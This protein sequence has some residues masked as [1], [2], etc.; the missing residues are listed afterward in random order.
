MEE[1]KTIEEAQQ[2]VGQYFVLKK[3]L[4]RGKFFGLSQLAITFLKDKELLCI[5]L[6]LLF[7]ISDPGYRRAIGIKVKDDHGK[8]HHVEWAWIQPAGLPI[9]GVEDLLHHWE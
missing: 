3:T 6:S 7:R 8:I 9:K 5:G 2:Y 1:P 4:T